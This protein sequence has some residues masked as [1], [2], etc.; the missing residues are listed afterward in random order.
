MAVIENTPQTQKL[1]QTDLDRVNQYRN[2]LSNFTYQ[3]GTLGIAEDNLNKQ[4]EELVKELDRLKQEEVNISRDF[5]EKYGKGQID[6][7]T[8]T[9]TITE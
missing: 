4:K 8:G 6:L 1:D 9:I 5:V 2:D 3:R 7:E